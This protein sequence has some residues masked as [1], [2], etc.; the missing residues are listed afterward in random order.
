MI[1]NFDRILYSR[2]DVFCFQGN[3]ALKCSGNSTCQIELLIK[4]VAGIGGM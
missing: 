4:Q 3:L 1:T 2:L